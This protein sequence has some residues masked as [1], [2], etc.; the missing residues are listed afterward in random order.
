MKCSFY[1]RKG[2][3]ALKDLKCVTILR[4]ASRKRFGLSFSDRDFQNTISQWLKQASLRYVREQR[5]IETT[6]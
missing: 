3:Y 1:G 6:E 5:K 4:E 2:N